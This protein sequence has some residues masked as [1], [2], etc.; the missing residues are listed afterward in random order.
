MDGYWKHV[1]LL[2]SKQLANNHHDTVHP[3]IGRF[4]GV[5]LF[6]DI[7]GF[8]ALSQKLDVD[9]LRQFINAYFKKLID[10]VRKYDGDIVKFAG[11]AMFIVWPVRYDRAGTIL[12]SLRFKSFAFSSYIINVL[13]GSFDSNHAADCVRRAV[14]CSIEINN[15]CSNFAVPLL[16]RPNKNLIVHKLLQESSGD[17]PSRSGSPIT[18]R[19]GFH[20]SSTQK[21]TKDEITFLNVH[22][23]ISLGCMAGLDVGEDGRWEYLLIGDPLHDVATAESEAE[24]GELVISPL[25]HQLLHGSPTFE[26]GEAAKCDCGCRTTKSGYFTVSNNLSFASNVNVFPQLT[27][28]DGAKFASLSEDERIHIL[29]HVHPVVRLSLQSL[30][31]PSVEMDADDNDIVKDVGS[32]AQPQSKSTLRERLQASIATAQDDTFLLAEKR[33][34]IVIF[35]NLGIS[36]KPLKV[37]PQSTP[38]LLNGSLRL[39][40]QTVG[41]DTTSYFLPTNEQEMQEDNAILNQYQ[42]CF[43]I[44]VQEFNN[45]QGHVRQFIVDDKGAVVIGTF[46]LRGSMNSDNAAVAIDT[47]RRIVERL[48]EISVTASIGITS[49]KAYCGLVGSPDRHE[50]AVMGPSVNLSARLMGKAG[51]HNI[52]CDSEIRLRDR[53]HKFQSLGEVQAKGYNHPV[54]IFQPV[55]RSGS[56]VMAIGSAYP[57]QRD[58]SSPNIR[59]SIRKSLLNSEVLNALTSVR[60]SFHAP[61]LSHQPVAVAVPVTSHLPFHREQELIGRD[62]VLIEMADFLLPLT[63]RPDNLRRVLLNISL[64]A[65]DENL[66]HHEDSHP[67]IRHGVDDEA[68]DEEDLHHKPF[69]K[70]ATFQTDH[71]TVYISVE[72]VAGVGKSFLIK[73]LLKRVSKARS[74]PTWNVLVLHTA[75]THRKNIAEPLLPWISV[76]QQACL[77]LGRHLRL[78]HAQ[79]RHTRRMPTNQRSHQ[80]N[81]YHA[82]ALQGLKHLLST[83]TADQQAFAPVFSGV[84]PSFHE[85]DSPVTSKLHGTSRLKKTGDLILLLLVALQQFLSQVVV[86]EL[87]NVVWL[88]SASLLLL[89]RIHAETKGFILIAECERARLSRVSQMMEGNSSKGSIRNQSS[90]L[91]ECYD[92][93]VSVVTWKYELR[94]L[95]DI[96]MAQLVTAWLKDYGLTE[97]DTDGQ[98]LPLIFKATGGNPVYAAELLQVCVDYIV[99]HDLHSPKDIVPRL[100]ELLHSSRMLKIEEVICYRFDQLSGDAQRLLKAASVACANGSGVTTDMLASLLRDDYD[101]MPVSRDLDSDSVEVREALLDKV[102]TLLSTEL[103]DGQFLTRAL[104]IADDM[105]SRS[106][107]PMPAS[108]AT[109]RLF[110]D[111]ESHASSDADSTLSDPV[112][113]LWVF[114]AELD[115]RVIY[116]LMLE[117]QQSMFHAK[118]A[119]QLAKQRY[120]YPAKPPVTMPSLVA[121]EPEE[122]SSPS[123][124]TAEKDHKRPVLRNDISAIQW[125]EEG[126]HWQRARMWGRGMTCFYQSGMV[127]DSL[128]ALQES[129]MHLLMAYQLLQQMRIALGGDIGESFDEDQTTVSLHV[130]EALEQVQ[131]QAFSRSMK[132]SGISGDGLTLP[133]SASHSPAVA[134]R[135]T[136]VP[137]HKGKIAASLSPVQLKKLQVYRL[138][139]GDRHL[140]ETGIH[141]LLRLAQSCLTLDNDSSVTAKLY[142]EALEMLTTIQSKG[143]LHGQAS[144]KDDCDTSPRL[145]SAA[146]EMVIFIGEDVF[147]HSHDELNFSSLIT[148]TAAEISHPLWR[149]TRRQLTSFGLKDPAICF[150][151]LSGLMVLYHTK[152]LADDE[153][154]SKEMHACEIFLSI[155]RSR[156]EYQPHQAIG[157]SFLRNIYHELGHID[158]GLSLI[159]EARSN[160]DYDSQTMTLI[161]IYGSDRMPRVFACNFQILLLRQDSSRIADYQLYLDQLFDKLSHLHTMAMMVM[162]LSASYVGGGGVLRGFRYFQRYLDFETRQSAFSHFRDIHPLMVTWMRCELRT[163][164]SIQRESGD[165]RTIWSPWYTVTLWESLRQGKP[166]VAPVEADLGTPSLALSNDDGDL[167]FTPTEWQTVTADELCGSTLLEAVRQRAF[168]KRPVQ[169]R[170][171]V[172][173]G[174]DFFGAGIEYVCARVLFLQ[175]LHGWYS[176]IATSTETAAGESEAKISNE[177]AEQTLMEDMLLVMEYL[178]FYLTECIK[179][180]FNFIFNRYKSLLLRIEACS[181]LRDLHT[182]RGDVSTASTIA[183]D[184]EADLASLHSLGA[185]HHLGLVLR[186]VNRFRSLPTPLAY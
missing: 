52:L 184:I 159:D 71:P 68:D 57:L 129:R 103:G 118:V 54:P 53:S 94:P 58:S 17:N 98:L 127:L 92:P 39:E 101:S 102:D 60:E 115:Q 185:D 183:R 114:A 177:A 33:E 42:Q 125:F 6:V 178:D 119:M 186:S 162:A 13:G 37:I 10:I 24:K 31:D 93:P 156:A 131:L 23:G 81:T 133:E 179:A 28:F 168:I 69:Q 82:L 112:A 63:R 56:V 166:L 109:N 97:Q 132:I 62:D 157:L 25:V 147:R 99:K 29:E 106:A 74:F 46:G 164:L 145:F 4:Y 152:K 12:T 22:S 1:P 148:T 171:F 91:E 165:P 7:S 120:I 130:G 126:F 140:L 45:N 88:D 110:P 123:K 32:Q 111:D 67:L 26:N 121:E 150:P 128:G 107:R 65:A 181:V 139:S 27:V 51:P 15:N 59:S 30:Q 21:P 9:H 175:A 117:E 73:S 49:G 167:Q 90:K 154:M 83:L 11:D 8:T 64:S 34:V 173:T 122:N 43:S 174:M 182:Q 144:S 170:S 163:L 3:S 136:L 149:I 172:Y 36:N 95:D 169:S 138:F 89:Q 104:T 161:K 72:G 77:Y 146:D 66:P 155:A 84:F 85:A 151:V 134:A 180:D 19:Q 100:I 160:Y 158:Q 48:D 5:L 143:L 55:F 41:T 137:L 141:V 135:K 38:D 35:V 113:D 70:S 78:S 79:H 2:L 176:H 14:Q 20:E 75:E 124:A 61:S 76:L 96:S 18:E 80:Q 50:Y 44:M 116:D 153:G 142:E 86:I 16:T 47:A 108:K 40:P 105:S 87:G